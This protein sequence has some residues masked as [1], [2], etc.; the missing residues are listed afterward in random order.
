MNI[1]NTVTEITNKHRKFPQNTWVEIDTYTM[2]KGYKLL[3]SWHRYD[4]VKGLWDPVYGS[5]RRQAEQ[6]EIVDDTYDIDCILARRPGRMS[7]SHPTED[8]YV[9]RWRGDH[10]QQHAIKPSSH[11]FSF[12]RDMVTH[13][14]ADYYVSTEI[15]TRGPLRLLGREQISQRAKRVAD[16]RYLEQLAKEEKWP[17]NVREYLEIENK[18]QADQWE[19][20]CTDN[21]EEYESFLETIHHVS[22]VSKERESQNEYESFMDDTNGT[23]TSVH[24]EPV[25]HNC[26]GAEA[27]GHNFE[28]IS[29]NVV[30]T[31]TEVNY[32]EDLNGLAKRGKK[33]S[34]SVHEFNGTPWTFEPRAYFEF[35]RDL[36]N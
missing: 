32:V 35:M 29:V 27:T 34:D 10:L 31:Q 6:Q 1:D 3:G 9:I 7:D 16:G 18:V 25:D 24:L 5:P 22:W 17:P 2:P 36:Y 21:A 14:G 12:K 30:S 15:Y 26:R 33:W 8:Q 19:S 11:L 23:V 13:L 20:W 4:K 28:E